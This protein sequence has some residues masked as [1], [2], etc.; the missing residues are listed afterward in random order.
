M[1]LAHRQFCFQPLAL[2][3]CDLLRRSHYPVRHRGIHARHARSAR[4]TRADGQ[5]GLS[6]GP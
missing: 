1:S 4:L 5:A 2:S 3:R 6:S